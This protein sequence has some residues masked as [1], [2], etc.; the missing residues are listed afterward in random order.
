[1]LTKFERQ[2]NAYRNRIRDFGKKGNKEQPQA[3]TPV[4]QE[5]VPMS[6]PDPVPNPVR[7]RRMIEMPAT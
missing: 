2:K 7:R 1:M 6:V 4:E 3:I 5:P